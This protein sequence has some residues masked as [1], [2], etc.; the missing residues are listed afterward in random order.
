MNTWM[1]DAIRVLAAFLLVA[2]SCGTLA[3]GYPAK[4]IRVVVPASPATSLD[5]LTRTVALE[6]GKRLGQAVIVENMPGAGGNIASASVARAV[7]DGYTLLMQI[8]SFVVNPSV[9]RKIAY[10]PVRDFQPVI[11][12]AWSAPTMLVVHPA[13]EGVSTVKDLVALS[14][15]RPGRLNY[16]SPGFGTP[17]HLAME[18]F[19]RMSGADF[20]HVP[21]KTPGEMVNAVLAGDVTAIF[22]SANVAIPQAKAGKLKI[23]AVTGEQRW[24]YTPDVPTM[25]E[26]GFPEFKFDIWFGFLA[27]SGTGADVVRKL[28]GEFAAVLNAAATKETLAKL[29][30][31]ATSGTPEEFAAQI[32]SDLA[33]WA[34]VVRD[35]G[36]SIE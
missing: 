23:V 32:R 10:D 8:T 11:L 17:Q 29:G 16:A 7:P 19:K 14:R 36:I 34:K 5:A 30:L 12:A 13:L 20:T 35:T 31:V 9:Y 21:F 1:L 18:I 28:N 24:M 15:S 6:L 26:S 25:A 27:P 4:P 22:A 2:A 33:Y 3:Q